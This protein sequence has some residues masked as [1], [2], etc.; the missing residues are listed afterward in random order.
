M[1]IYPSN[2]IWVIR[3]VVE[4]PCLKKRYYISRGRQWHPTLSSFSQYYICLSFWKL[5]V[6][7]GACEKRNMQVTALLYA[8]LFSHIYEGA[9]L[10]CNCKW[11]YY[12]YWLFKTIMKAYQVF[13]S[14]YCSLVIMSIMHASCKSFNVNDQ[15][16]HTNMEQTRIKTLYKSTAKSLQT[17]L[18]A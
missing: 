11:Q 1:Q 5:W 7:V 3:I 12:F 13:N 14:N 10:F 18:L 8:V 15:F 17:S 6:T 2:P 9:K 16:Y 4:S